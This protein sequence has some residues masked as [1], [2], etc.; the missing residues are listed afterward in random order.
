M[1]LKEINNAPENVNFPLLVGYEP[2][3]K[4][5]LFNI[6]ETKI[7]IECGKKKLSSE[8][9]KDKTRKCGLYPICKSCRKDYKK[10]YHH[11]KLGLSAII[12]GGQVERSKS[13]KWKFP[14]YNLQEFRIW[15]FSQ[16]W[17][18]VLYKAWIKSGYKKTLTPSCHRLDDYKPYT[19]DNLQVISWGKHNTKSHA[20]RKNGINNKASKAVIGIHKITGEV[21]EFYSMMEAQRQT[22]IHYS[23]ISKC[24]IGHKNYSHAGGYKWKF[25]EIKKL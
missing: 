12:Y 7:C 3:L 4:G 23:N 20:D 2:H 14:T 18:H 5:F 24:C 16:D 22:G 1:F 15:L 8:F 21:V 6:M 19:L 25:K 10:E 13:K 9:S 17:F 11:S